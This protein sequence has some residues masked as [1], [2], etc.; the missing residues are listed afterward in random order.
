M[1]WA[2]WGYLGNAAQPDESFYCATSVRIYDLCS[3][4]NFY[5]NIF[6]FSCI[7]CSVTMFQCMNHDTLMTLYTTVRSPFIVV[8]ICHLQYKSREK[9]RSAPWRS[10]KR[11]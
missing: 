7:C 9:N 5:L 4:I 6:Y 2:Y 11:K 10:H 3:N 8:N 1:K